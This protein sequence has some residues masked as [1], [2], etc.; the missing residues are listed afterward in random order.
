[1]LGNTTENLRKRV[2]VKLVTDEKTD[3]IN[4]KTNFVTS[5]ICDEKLVA[6]Q[7]IKET[8]TPNWPAYVGTYLRSYK[9]LMYDFHYDYI[10]KKYNDK[11]KLLFTDTDSLT[12]EIETEDAYEDFWSDKVNSV[13]VN[14]QKT[15][16]IQINQIK[17]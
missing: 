16:H 17:K 14:I 7:K 10:K 8:M 12:Y 9:T 11:A 15:P 1:M 3:E 5:K 4:I 6:I 2:D 13:T